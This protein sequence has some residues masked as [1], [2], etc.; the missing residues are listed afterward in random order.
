MAGVLRRLWGLFTQDLQSPGA[1]GV[2]WPSTCPSQDVGRHPWFRTPISRGF[3]RFYI[4]RI[5]PAGRGFL[6]ACW[7]AVCFTACS[8]EIQAYVLLCFAFA[9]W[10]VAISVAWMFRP[11]VEVHV[12]HAPK[13]TAG[14]WVPITVELIQRGSLAGLPAR[15]LPHRL[16]AGVR[17]APEAGIDFRL[18]DVGHQVRLDL[19]LHCERRGVYT[20]P[21]FRIETAFPFGLVFAPRVAGGPRRLL[22]SPRFSP[23]QE[24]TGLEGRR[25]QPGGVALAARVGDAAEYL[26]NREYRE[27]D[28]LRTMDWRA[29]ARLDRPIVREFRDE[30]FQRVAVV[31]DNALPRRP[32]AADCDTFEAA[33]SLSAAVCECLSRQE[34]LVEL[35][36]TGNAVHHLTTGRGLGTLDQ[37]LELLAC[38]DSGHEDLSTALETELR[39]YL[40]QL[41]AVVCVFLDWD[42]A[43][44]KLVDR[45]SREGVAVKVLVVRAGPTTLPAE[46]DPRCGAEVRQVDP[47]LVA[48]GLEVL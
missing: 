34:C 33:I 11:R 23:I 1:L 36:A 20:L 27:G 32:S 37:V 28:N 30:Y 7:L 3:W 19:A 26:G 48:A 41:T 13:V 47:S 38:V 45:L 12:T 4:E 21:G 25:H 24:L 43:R 2:V 31:L 46:E 39:P 40:G 6:W 42:F 15:C 35:F 29:T 18:N 10:V 16:P 17:A 9:F 44:S 22:V 5:T 14:G 8:L